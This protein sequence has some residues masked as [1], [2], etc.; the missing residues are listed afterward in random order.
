MMICE[1]FADG[2]CKC[3]DCLGGKPH[4]FLRGVCDIIHDCGQSGTVFSTRCIDYVEPKKETEMPKVASIKVVDETVKETIKVIGHSIPMGTV[5]RGSI[6]GRDTELFIKSFN[7][8]VVLSSYTHPI[9]DVYGPN[10]EVDHYQPVE[11]E[12]KL[13]RNL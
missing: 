8:M 1:A 5:F 12:I 6:G 13:V 10:L 11:I 4:N 7:G 9:G 2:D 3:K